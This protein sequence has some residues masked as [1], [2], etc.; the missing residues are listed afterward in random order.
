[1]RYFLKR[2]QGIFASGLWALLAVGCGGGSSVSSLPPGVLSQS[3]THVAQSTQTAAANVSFAIGIRPKAKAGVVQPR[4]VSPSTQSLQVLV[5]G[6]KGIIVNLTPQSPNC[7]PNPAVS[8]A[9]VCSASLSVPAGSHVFT[10]TTY[11]LTAGKG[12]VLSTNSTGPVTVK[13]TGTTTISLVLQGQVKYV[14]LALAPTNP[15]LGAAAAIGL[16][17]TLEDADQNL[18]IGRTPY[19]YAVTLTTSNA[20][21]GPLSKTTLKSPADADGITVNYSGANVAAIT[22]SAT[23]RGLRPPT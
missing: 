8:G 15:P 16:T 22:L 21:A 5:D 2:A 3:S 19:E 12:N 18:I 9:Y 10:V 17:A 6:A 14:L 23:A 4:Y 13:P 1:M 7:S 11:D 20:T